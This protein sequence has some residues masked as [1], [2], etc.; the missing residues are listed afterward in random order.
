MI[1]VIAPESRHF[2]L[3]PV[4]F[5]NGLGMIAALNDGRIILISFKSV[6]KSL[7]T[8]ALHYFLQSPYNDSIESSSHLKASG[9][10]LYPASEHIIL[11]EFPDK[12]RIYDLLVHVTEQSVTFA[13]NDE[14]G[15]PIVIEYEW[16]SI[17]A[18]L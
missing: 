9:P 4:I 18:I 1:T 17:T 2:I 5:P 14:W 6:I 8:S 12:S 10:R 16:D 3:C 7:S 13:V 11:A 15:F